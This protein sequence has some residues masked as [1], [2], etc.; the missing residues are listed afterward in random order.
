MI[1]V[2]LILRRFRQIV[3]SGWSGQYRLYLRSSLVGG[4]VVLQAALHHAG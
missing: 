2:G 1:D 4:I 3:G